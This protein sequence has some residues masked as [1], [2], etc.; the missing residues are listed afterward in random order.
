MSGKVPATC[1]SS[2]LLS[3][4]HIYYPNQAGDVIVFKIDE[5]PEIVSVNSLAEKI[6]SSVVPSEGRLYIR[7][8]AHLWCIGQ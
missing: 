5:K 8:D 3:G 7:T 2:F 6:N 4:E 1:W